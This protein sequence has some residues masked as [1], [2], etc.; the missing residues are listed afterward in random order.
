MRTIRTGTA[1]AVLT[2][3]MALSGVVARA[4]GSPQGG[5]GD[6][7]TI[8]GVDLPGTIEV[9]AQKLLLNGAA[10]RKIA[11]IKIYVAGLYLENKQNDP[12]AILNQDAPRSLMMHFLRDVEAKKLCEGWDNSLSQNTPN[13]SEEL[14]AQFVTLCSWMEDAAEGERLRFSYTPGHGT[15]VEYLGRTR[16]PIVGKEFSDAL[17]RTWLGPDSIPGE[18][19]KRHLLGG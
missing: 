18:D 7:A 8:A 1:A 12:G 19:F 16:G 4:A 15:T 5:D 9:E 6:G 3:M 11:F 2:A 10:L 13:P 14:K 17:F